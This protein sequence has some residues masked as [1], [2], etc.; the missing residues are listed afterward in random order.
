MKCGIICFVINLQRDN[1]R[2]GVSAVTPPNPTFCIQSPTWRV[3]IGVFGSGDTQP[4]TFRHM[5]PQIHVVAKIDILVTRLRSISRHSI[6]SVRYAF[7]SGFFRINGS[8]ILRKSET[9]Y[10][11]QFCW[12]ILTGP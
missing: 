5:Y 3:R 12:M 8:A 4:S 7:L 2:S 6:Y 11:E 10:E 9:C 1:Q